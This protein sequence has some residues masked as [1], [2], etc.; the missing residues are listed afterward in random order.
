[1]SD[2]AK[3]LMVGT[4]R[5]AHSGISAV[6]NELYGAGLDNLVDIKYIGT[7]KEG[8]K[9]KKFII[10]ALAFARFKKELS[11]CDLVHIHFSSDSS[12]WRKSFFIKSAYRHGKKIVLHQHG[13]DFKTYYGSEIG[14][15]GKRRVKKILGMGDVLLVL[16]PSWKEFFAQIVT[17][18]KIEVFPNG[19]R[20]DIK[21]SSSTKDYSKALFLGRVCRDKGIDE[22][23]LAMDEIHE[24]NPDAKLYIGGIY[25]DQ[26]YRQ[27]V[28]SRREYVIFLG[29]ITGE[30]KE[31]LLQECGILVL[32]SYYEGM[33][34][35]IIEGML[36]CCV[37]VATKVGGIPEI[38]DDGVDGL[39]ISPGDSKALTNAMLKVMNDKTYAKDLGNAG[40][41]KVMSNYSI[42][43]SVSRLDNIYSKLH[44]L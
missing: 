7:F 8:S 4:D 25:E 35:S 22:L 9:L 30:Q 42:E 2:K 3:V 17:E 20:T 36:N 44:K 39:L 31:K 38:I 18:T 41:K 32:P 13:G 19:V 11:W 5:A 29:W 27:K 24:N 28:D 34:V 23:L 6:V 37:P 12:F 14:E 26:E 40:R 21:E 1:M 10:A 15:L 33:P 43:K 16:T